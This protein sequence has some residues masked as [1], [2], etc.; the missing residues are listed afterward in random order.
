[1]AT[2]R[3]HADEFPNT[4]I[5]SIGPA[6]DDVQAAD[7]DV[8]A[9]QVEAHCPGEACEY[10]DQQRDGEPGPT[11]M[12][13]ATEYEIVHRADEQNIQHQ[14]EQHRA[15]GWQ[16]VD[17]G[18]DG[19]GNRRFVIVEDAVGPGREAIGAGDQIEP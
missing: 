14:I 16:Q 7:D 3:Q 5:L 8:V 11:T 2:R 19:H 10:G 6:F 13:D 18:H 15:N 12:V 4:G 17:T 9:A 1:M